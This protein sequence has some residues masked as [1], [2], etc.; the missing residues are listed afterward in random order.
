[1][2]PLPLCVSLPRPGTRTPRASRPR[3]PDRRARDEVLRA[4]GSHVT[5]ARKGKRPGPGARDTQAGP[6]L[7]TTG[8]PGGPAAMGHV[9][10][11]AR[12]PP[13]PQ[14]GRDKGRHPL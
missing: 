9:Q 4:G 1:M 12:A 2:R 5:P 6:D 8:P 11:I 14:A 10:I 3:A 13:L 7:E